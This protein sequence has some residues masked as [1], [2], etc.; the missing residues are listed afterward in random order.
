M[1]PIRAGTAFSSILFD[2][3]TAIKLGT[4]DQRVSI[5]KGVGA[6][7]EE[8]LD[9]ILVGDDDLEGPCAPQNLRMA[10]PMPAAP[11]LSVTEEMEED[12]E[13]AVLD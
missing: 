10:V 8:E 7:T 6:M 11:L 12:L 13:I 2:E 5:K 3:A 9:D 1:V 4:P